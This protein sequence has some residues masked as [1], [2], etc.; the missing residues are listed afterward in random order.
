MT[1]SKRKCS[2]HMRKRGHTS[3]LGTSM[4]SLWVRVRV[5]ALTRS[6]I[7][8][9]SAL[10][11]LQHPHL[12][13]GH[14]VLRTHRH[15]TS[16]SYPLASYTMPGTIYAVWLGSCASRIGPVLPPSALLTTTLIAIL[17]SIH[18]RVWWALPRPAAPARRNTPD[19]IAPKLPLPLPLPLPPVPPRDRLPALLVLFFSPQPLLVIAITPTLSRPHHHRWNHYYQFY[20]CCYCWCQ[21]CQR[22]FLWGGGLSYPLSTHHPQCLSS[23]ASS[24]CSCSYYSYQYYSWL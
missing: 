24:S 10:L 13:L 8:Y 15:D 11:G 3:L 14:G 2:T 22:V 12:L 4:G 20:Y 18:V 17:R 7:A 23:S 19:Q 21:R 16:T 5:R 1:Q 6:S 9:V